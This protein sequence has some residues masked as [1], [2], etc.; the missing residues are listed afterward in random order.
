MSLQP[1]NP[2]SNLWS[3]ETL[4]AGVDHVM[5]AA[6]AEPV[7]DDEAERQLLKQLQDRPYMPYVMVCVFLNVHWQH[8]FGIYMFSTGHWLIAH[9]EVESQI[10]AGAGSSQAWVSGR[11]PINYSHQSLQILI[12]VALPHDGL[13]DTVPAKS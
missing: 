4:Q 7:S 3:C 6:K 12:Q 5:T 8:G 10:N 11:V 1:E 13:T 2:V 9:Q